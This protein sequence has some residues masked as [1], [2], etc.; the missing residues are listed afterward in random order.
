MRHTPVSALNMPHRRRRT[1]RCTHGAWLPPELQS[2]LSYWASLEATEAW[3]MARFLASD[4]ERRSRCSF[5]RL[6]SSL[7]YSA[8]STFFC[9]PHWG[10]WRQRRNVVAVLWTCQ[11]ASRA[12]KQHIVRS[13]STAK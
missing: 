11:V 3:R 6:I 1:P 10:D 7:W 12:C 8:C 9:V 2:R 4:S 5:S 13:C